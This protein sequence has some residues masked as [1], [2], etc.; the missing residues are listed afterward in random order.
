MTFARLAALLCSVLL[1]VGCGNGDGDG[2]GGSAGSSSQAGSGG[3][4]NQTSDCANVGCAPPPHCADGCQET[5]GCC[6][7]ADGELNERTG[8]SYRCEGGC[9]APLAAAVDWVRLQL[10][11]GWGPCPGDEICAEQWIARPDGSIETTKGGEM[12]SA[13]M[14]NAD[15]EALAVI[16]ADPEFLSGMM[17][18]FDCGIPPS[19]VAYNMTLELPD[20][21]YVEDVTG[22]VLTGPA[23]NAAERAVELVSKY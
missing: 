17:S 21:E 22:C 8:T 2:G 15:R 4:G 20:G 14:P 5:C 9:Y 1:A 19:D 16:I 12:Q 10:D 23:G 3:S 7:S 11:E 6:S 13:T 18:G